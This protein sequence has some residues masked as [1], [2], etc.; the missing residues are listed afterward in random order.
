MRV[1][2]PRAALYYLSIS[3]IAASTLFLNG[4]STPPTPADN[5]ASVAT[6]ATIEQANR[7]LSQG[8]KREA[9]QA[10]FSAAS[11]YPSPQRERIV[12]QAAELS[13]SLGDAN[14]TNQ[15]L[16]S[17]PSNLDGENQGR[18]AYVH[19]LLALQQ[20]DAN[21][22]LRTL[23]Q[24]LD[25]L[26]PALREKVKHVQQQALSKGGKPSSTAVAQAAPQVQ[27]A[28]VP[29]SVN[30]IAALLPQSGPLGSVGREI[31][32]GIE[33]AR[34]TLAPETTVQLYDVSSG[35]TVGQYQRAVA[36]GADMVIGPL[37]KDALAQLLAQPQLLSKPILSLNYLSDN[38]F[39]P[40]ALYQFGLLPEDEARQ[41]AEYASA[42]GQRT[43]I[44]MIPNSNWG[45]RVGAA[46]RAAYQARGGQVINIQQYPDAPSNA[47]MQ[48]VQSA[49]AAT[50]GRASMVFL[51]GSPS[52][53]RLM[54][55]LLAAQAPELPVYATSHVFGGRTDPGKDSDLD[56]IVYTEI[57]WIMEGLQNGTLNNSAFPRMFALGMDSFLI[58]KNLP[59]IARTPNALVQ[60]KTGNITLSGNRQVQ[61]QLLMATFVNGIPQPLGQ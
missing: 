6:K 14:L 22:A 55:P 16:A 7:L 29:V 52:Q 59:S 21:L 61:R 27:P 58:S 37:D 24:N 48:N 56:G 15:Y 45:D 19:A 44:L 50:Q 41:V 51:A 47:Y 33:A 8:K 10:Y 32:R 18:L 60:G 9:A 1:N 2:P 54:R 3:L 46:F 30:R 49:L 11:S 17:L 42:R 36:D 57:P 4:C 43:A 40:G 12:L 35:N 39:I 31:Y 34:S 38:R 25:A 28:L 53:A 26:S 23:P 20:G 13:A 5:T